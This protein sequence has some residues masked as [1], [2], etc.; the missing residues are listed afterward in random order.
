MLKRLFSLSKTSGA[1]KT[2]IQLL[3]PLED[4]DYEYLFLQLLEG[5]AHG[6]QQDRILRFFRV[7][8]DRGK[9]DLWIDWLNR[10]QEKLAKAPTIDNNLA[11]RMVQMGERHGGDL[12]DLAHGI[13]MK[14]LTGFQIEDVFTTIAD[15]FES[16]PLI[17]TDPEPLIPL[18]TETETTE[19]QDP[20]QT[21]SLNELLTMMQM[22]GNLRKQVANQFGIESDDPVQIIEELIE[23]LQISQE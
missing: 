13:G 22:D 19:N 2:A 16:Q 18:E 1:K 3:P 17:I 20:T 14:M 21:V 10:Y 9:S 8:G 7:L 12:G 11:M 15:E 4:A 5:V 23:K 6:W